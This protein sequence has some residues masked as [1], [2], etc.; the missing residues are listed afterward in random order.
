MA[1]HSSILAYRI[2][3]TEDPGGL[4]P[5]GIAKSET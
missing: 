2:P 1:T 4:P 5:S 3:S